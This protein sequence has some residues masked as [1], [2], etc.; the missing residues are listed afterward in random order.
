MTW[1]FHDG[2]SGPA[3]LSRR[4]IEVRFPLSNRAMLTLTHDKVLME[5]LEKSGDRKS[6]R[7]LSRLPE[8][9]LAQMSDATVENVNRTNAYHSTHW[10]FSGSEQSWISAVMSQPSKRIRTWLEEGPEGFRLSKTYHSWA[11]YSGTP[12]PTRRNLGSTSTMRF[13]ATFRPG[14]A[15]LTHGSPAIRRR[16]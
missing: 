1:I 2:P 5:K 7:I 12:L 15:L 4:D 11:T 13:T 10:A 9:R 14:Q 16:T 3:S 6:P 8:V